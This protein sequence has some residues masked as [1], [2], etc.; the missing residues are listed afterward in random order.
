MKK[1][2]IGLVSVLIL[3]LIIIFSFIFY[4]QWH[5]INGNKIVLATQPIDPFDPFRGQYISINYEISSINDIG[6][7]NEKDTIYVSLKE[8]EYG[9]WRFKN[10]SKSKP[11]KGDFIKG[12][13]TNIHS[14]IIRIE[15]GIEQF[16]FERNAKLPTLN[17]TVEVSVSDSGR[18]KL[19]QLLHNGK[20]IEIGYE[21][22]DIKS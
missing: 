8:D 18:A 16:F 20:P 11:L 12:K 1:Q 19:V 9:I 2:F 4:N 22:F 10:A 6:G 14:N 17:I 3:I 13:I 15:Y 5:L 7:F 21:E